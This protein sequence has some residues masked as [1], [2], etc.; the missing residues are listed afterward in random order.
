MGT[1]RGFGKRGGFS[2]NSQLGTARGF[3]KRDELDEDVEYN[4]DNGVESELIV[5]FLKLNKFLL[6]Y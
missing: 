2:Y 1:A 5:I 3:G 4:S 6:K